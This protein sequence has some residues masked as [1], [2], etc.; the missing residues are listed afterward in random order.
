VVLSFFHKVSLHNIQRRLTAWFSG[1]ESCRF[2][3]SVKD[4]EMAGRK[5]GLRLKLK[6]AQAPFL[7]DLWAVAFIKEPARESKITEAPMAFG[8]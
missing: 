4:L 1:R 3:S 8:E 2:A 7:R 6:A 5:A